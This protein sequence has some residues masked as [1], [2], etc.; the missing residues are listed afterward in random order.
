MTSVHYEVAGPTLEAFFASDDFVRVLVGPFGSG[1]TTACIAEAFRRIQEQAPDADGIR[2]SR[3][4]VIRSTY[5]QLQSTT[6]QSWRSWFGDAFGDFT[7][8]DPFQHRMRFGLA[9]GTRVEADI[10]FLAL[11][12]PE[13]EAKLRGLEVSWAWVNECREIP[14]GVFSFLTG[15]VGRYPAMRDGG[16][17]WSGVFADT[18]PWD[19]DHWLHEAPGWRVFKQPGG[20]LWDGKAWV[21][22]PAA[23]NLINLPRRLLRAPARGSDGRLDP[24]LSRRRVR[25]RARRQA[26]LSGV[27]RQPARA[28]GGDR[29]ATVRAGRDR[30]RFR[31]DARGRV[32]PDRCAR[33]VARARPSSSPPTWVPR[34]SPGCCSSTSRPGSPARPP[35]SGAIR[36]A[37]QRAQ[38]DERT[39]LEVIRSVTGLPAH[40]APTNSFLP[41]REAV[42]GALG[43]LIEGVPGLQI[44]PACKVL[45]KGFAGGYHYRRLKVAGDERYHDEPNK[46]GFSHVH[47]ALQ[48]ALSG[49]GETLR[50]RS[51]RARS[52]PTTAFKV[53]P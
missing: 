29:T 50:P 39:C 26:D 24:G 44:S 23:E 21:P 20:V 49:G 14:K 12:G 25:F 18:N 27:P 36:P 9:D 10:V 46:N 22:N 11:D 30:R 33:P 2:R 5:R 48:Y 1:K 32:L 51:T 13:A 53:L 19:V 7:W 42:A 40:A 15:R 38:T 47:D 6:A 28:G 4:V 45:R 16:P 35:G 52:W 37:A 43:R 34:H 8:S 3:G 17:T 31:P 41:R